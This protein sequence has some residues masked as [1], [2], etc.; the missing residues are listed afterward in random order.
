MGLPLIVKI[1]KCTHV[2]VRLTN[3][4]SWNKWQ[5]FTLS[6]DPLIPKLKFL[7]HMWELETNST[8]LKYI[9][10]SQLIL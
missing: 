6:I 4:L 3:F 7:K 2:V 8:A 5:F 9:F 10:D 1:M